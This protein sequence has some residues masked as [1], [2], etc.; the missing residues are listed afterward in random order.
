MLEFGTPIA[1]VSYVERPGA[2]AI[3][4]NDSAAIAVVKTEKG[5]FLPGGGVDSGEEIESAL[6]REIVEEIGYASEIG[7]KIGTAAQY[8]MAASEK[9][10]Y[11]KIG[12]F[13]LATLGAKISDITEHELVWL[14]PEE[15]FK[16]LFRQYQAWAVREACNRCKQKS[17]GIV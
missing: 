2:Y 16:M 4:K 9:K 13:Y 6:K 11:K 10:H 8:L 15:S 3:I 14:S 12:H 5:Y 17:P 1:G 7:E